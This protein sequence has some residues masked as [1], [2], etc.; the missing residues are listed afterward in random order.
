[1]KSRTA[2]GSSTDALRVV[3]L[4]AR[5]Q[6]ERI[7]LVQRRPV[8]VAHAEVQGE[9]RPHPPLVLHIAGVGAVRQLRAGWW[10][11]E[12]SPRSCW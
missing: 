8:F 3:V 4:Q 10:R 2:L 9:V 1:M 7:L 6:V 12:R 5:R 11:R